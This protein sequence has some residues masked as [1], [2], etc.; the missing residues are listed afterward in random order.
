MEG[1]IKTGKEKRLKEKISSNPYEKA[2]QVLKKP[3]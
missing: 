3:F 2:K 1:E